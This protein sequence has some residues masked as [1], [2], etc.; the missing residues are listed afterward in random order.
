[1]RYLSI[2][3]VLVFFTTL[4][5]ASHFR[6]IRVG[7]F[8]NKVDA[9]KSLIKLNKYM[10]TQRNIIHFQKKLFF[11]AKAIKVGRYYMNVIEPFGDNQKELQ[12]IV[13]TIRKKYPHAYIKKVKGKMPKVKHSKPVSKPKIKE[14][15]KKE[16]KKIIQP[17]VE[18]VAEPIVITPIVIPKPIIEK[19]IVPIIIEEIVE[20]IIIQ[21]KN[22]TLPVVV[23]EKNETIIEENISEPII[24]QEKNETIIEENISEP[25]IEET[26]VEEVV[27]SD[28]QDVKVIEKEN[29]E[30]EIAVVEVEEQ[31]EKEVEVAVVEIEEQQEKEIEVAVVEV[32]EEQEKEVEVAVVEVEEQ[33]EKEVEVAIVEVKENKILHILNTVPKE[34]KFLL[35]ALI[36]V[37]FFLF[38]ILL[39]LLK[40]VSNLKKEKISSIDSVEI[41]QTEKLSA[42]E[43]QLELVN[44][45]HENSMMQLNSKHKEEISTLE[46]SY[47]RKIGTINLNN[48]NSLSE[49][50]LNHQ[51]DM[52]ELIV[53]NKD[54]IQ[55]IEDENLKQIEV[56]RVELSNSKTKEIQ[57]EPLLETPTPIQELKEPEVV[58]VIIEEAETEELTSAIGLGNCDGDEQF[59]NTI[60]AEFKT[61]YKESPLTFEKLCIEN[62]FEDAR[63][64]AGDI[65]DLAVNIGAYNL[66]ESV[67]S[68]EYDFEKGSTTNWKKRVENYKEKLEKL[69]IEIDDYTNKN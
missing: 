49:L 11:R 12:E 31:Q 46:D 20:P 44:T 21:E 4:L 64:L 57:T 17:I 18:K 51:N 65:K 27:I 38:V 33:Q 13:D 52:D 14:V 36:S 63:H 9:D 59:Y 15:I 29:K 58:P 42:L 60:L 45:T 68:M 30:S 54:K 35:I 55:K 48:E 66:C 3:M 32:K 24:I 61:S 34:I 41:E 50:L 22:E 56:L 16:P 25:I 10:K 40:K 69:I 53:S 7:S 8:L 5:N 6:S 37:I 28:L 47:N 23:Q 43:K 1:M 39:V 26:L 19:K 2:I 62:N 67:A